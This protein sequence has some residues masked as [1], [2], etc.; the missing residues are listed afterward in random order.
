LNDGLRTLSFNKKQTYLSE[1]LDLNYR[2]AL[3]IAR[4]GEM[5]ITLPDLSGGRSHTDPPVPLPRPSPRDC[6]NRY[7]KLLRTYKTLTRIVPPP[8]STAGQVNGDCSPLGMADPTHPEPGGYHLLQIRIVY[9]VGS[10]AGASGT[11][12]SAGTTLAGLV[13]RQPSPLVKLFQ[14]SPRTRGSNTTAATGSASVDATKGVAVCVY[15]TSYSTG[16]LRDVDG[17]R[18]WLPTVDAL[19]Q[20]AVFDISIVAPRHWRV[21]SCGKKLSTFLLAHDSENG[22]EGPRHPLKERKI[23]RFFTPNR[24]AAMSVGFYTG[25]VEM[26]K[27]P[28]Y[29]LRSRMWVSLGITDFVSTAN[30]AN[31]P[32]DG[33]SGNDTDGEARSSSEDAENGNKV[34]LR[35]LDA[36]YYTAFKRTLP[37]KTEEAAP[38]SAVEEEPLSPRGNPRKRQR[39]DSTGRSILAGAAAAAKAEAAVKIDGRPTESDDRTAESRAVESAQQEQRRVAQ[40]K[41]RK[42]SSREEALL[43]ASVPGVVRSKLYER[44]VQHTTLGLDISL[45]LLHKFTGHRHD[46]DEI[47]MVFVAELGTDYVAYD[48]FLLVDAKFLH[49]EA[50]VQMETPAHLVLLQAYLYSWLKSALPVSSYDCEFILHGAVGY[51]MNFYA[52][53]VFGEEDGR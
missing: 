45:R 47:I 36:S 17:V 40:D 7:E 28:L 9:T 22:Q 52:E 3:E 24:I 1:E 13:F 30:G 10:T 32:E 11:G 19:D 4:T 18:C 43:R 51:L 48:G 6:T 29:K 2:A 35:P 46:Y 34:F 50:E 39:A 38:V 49:S 25:A 26:Y 37:A 5:Q 33:D 44:V 15:S 14:P 42:R 21:V 53:E 8:I 41:R 12:A 31:G 27:M 23:T 16:S 20:R